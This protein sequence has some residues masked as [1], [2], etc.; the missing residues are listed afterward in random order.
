M[1]DNYFS[2]HSEIQEKINRLQSVKGVGKQTAIVFAVYMPELGEISDKAAAA[3]VGV[4]PFNRDSGQTRNYC[5]IQY[6]RHQIRH[7][8][9][10]AAVCASRHNPIF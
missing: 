6:G 7:V 10:M 4:A 5:S 1:I 8:L 2:S 9:Y 3:L